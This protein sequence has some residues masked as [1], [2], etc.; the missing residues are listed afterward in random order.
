M[1]DARALMSQLDALGLTVEVRGQQLAVTPPDAITDE[2]RLAI[3]EAKPAILRLL[4]RMP[5]DARA[6]D[7]AITATLWRINV[8]WVSGADVSELADLHEAVNVACYREDLRDTLSALRRYE[9][10]ARCL[11]E[12]ADLN[13]ADCPETKAMENRGENA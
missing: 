1:T 9:D 2:L 12:G 10:R 6:A 11:A 8:F 5:W 4:T 3:R 7:D 13:R